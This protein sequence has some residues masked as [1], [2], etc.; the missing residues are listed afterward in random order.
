LNKV[1]ALNI[2][3][4]YCKLQVS[5]C[6][7]QEG[8]NMKT[9]KKMLALC[10]ALAMFFTA[11]SVLS[12]SIF[13]NS[14]KKAAI[15]RDG[16]IDFN[17]NGTKD[18]YENPAAKIDDRVEDLLARM[19]L[20]EKTAQMVT[21]YGY[22]RVLKD[23]LPTEEWKTSFWKDGIANIDEHLNNLAYN[24]QAATKYSWPPSKHARAINEVQRFF[25]EETR[26]GIPVDF[27]NEGIYGLCHDRATSF[28]AQIGQGSTWDK[29]LVRSIGDI[30]GREARIL[31]YT[32]VYSPILDL[33]R[34]PRW[35]RTVECYG[36]DP[37]HVSTLGMEMVRGIQGRK[38][39][40]TGKH[41]AVY[42]VPKGGRDGRARTDPQASLHEVYEILL[43]PFRA[44]V[45]EAGILGLMSSYNDYDTIPVSADRHFMT[46][47]LNQWG[48]KGYIV[49]DSGAV[50]GLIDRHHITDSMKECVFQT[51]MAGL[52]VRTNFN[53]PEIFADPLRELVKEGRIP[54]GVIDDRV[55]RVLRV[56]FWLGLFDSPYVENPDEADKLVR[57]D[58][59]KEV[60][61]RSSRESLVLLKN[62][63][64]L[65]VNINSINTILV[66]GPNAKAV[67]PMI[68]RYGPSNLDVITIY[69]GIKKLVGDKVEVKY[70][71]GCDHYDTNWPE[72][73]LYRKA[74]SK[75]QKNLIDDAVQKA[76]ISDL[77]IV[78]VGDDEN[79]VGESRSRTSLDLPGNQQDLVQA[80]HETG[81]P[82]L[83]VLLNGRPVTIN[84]ID[85][86]I[87]AIIEA[88]FPSEY[89]GQAV[90]E[91]IFG[92]YNPGGKLPV[93]FPKTV[94]QLPYNFP[95]KTSSQ[96]DQ[97]VKLPERV[98]AQVNGD[99]YPFGYGLSYT[100]FEY[101]DLKI[102]P[103][104]TNAGKDIRVSFT[105]KNVGAMKGDEVPQLYFSDVLCSVVTYEKRLAGFERITLTPNEVKTVEFTI[106]PEKQLAIFNADMKEVVEPGLFEIY[107]G[108]SSEDVRLKGNFT[109]IE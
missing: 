61:L 70:A 13:I 92:L 34:D 101:A 93:T 87:P 90:A 57:N 22:G 102:T 51:V 35:G 68:S 58:E 6:F 69:D 63:G 73:E 9:G 97:P 39:V 24:P 104:E 82:I 5:L 55:R 4:Y 108:S 65:P 11:A 27:T 72:S 52:N 88:W 2:F 20:E 85:K 33:A 91:A 60:S 81:K 78:V 48:F 47:L 56:K 77:V 75:T 74:P 25:V 8:S 98:A 31:G 43:K 14:E 94:G 30:T 71:K 105:V 96:L 86:Y 95:H 66:T 109:I 38:V 21:L 37:F 50:E 103:S 12:Q 59:A 1:A 42:S 99:L 17:K 40:S 18:V 32:N 41:F 100:K 107:V 89:A 64:L 76:K 79:T 29:N 62:N 84:W 49:S 54:M 80:L 83:V 44:A 19:T 45:S 7:Q 10:A 26:L 46:D 28:P 53:P 15:Y 3:I 67:N 36:E 16:W 23:E 106:V